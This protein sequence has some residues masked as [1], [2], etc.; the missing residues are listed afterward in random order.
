LSRKAVRATGMGEL[1]QSSNTNEN[2]LR[3]SSLSLRRI[4]PMRPGRELGIAQPEVKT[5]DGRS[6]HL[7]LVVVA[8]TGRPGVGSGG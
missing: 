4:R 3:P 5:L 8:G 6:E 7:A 1:N 2:D